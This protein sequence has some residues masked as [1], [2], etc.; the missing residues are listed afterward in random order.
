MPKSTKSAASSLSFEAKH[1][2]LSQ[3]LI[4]GL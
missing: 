3:R 4:A 1:S 2:A